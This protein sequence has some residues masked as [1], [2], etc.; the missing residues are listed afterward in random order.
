MK[1][2]IRFIDKQT[3]SDAVMRLFIQVNRVLSDDVVTALRTAEQR[4]SVPIAQCVLRRLGENLDAARELD[5][6]ICQDTGMAIVFAEVGEHVHIT[7]GTLF[8]AIND[9]VSRAYVEGKLRCSVVSDPLYDRKNTGDNTPA[10][11]HMTTVPGDT[12][13][14]IAAPKGFGSE[15]MSAL[16][17]LTPA[18]DEDTVADFVVSAVRA[19]GS[20]PCPP[21]L[22]G[23]GIGSDFEGVALLSKRALLRPVGTPHP[24]ARYAALEKKILNRVNALG[25]GPQGFGGDITALAVHIEYAPTHI[26]GLPCAVNINCHVIRHAEVIL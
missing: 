10:V 7:G 15:N 6:P 1:E 25:I 4:E 12:L 19:A 24:D 26:A 14:L 17:M 9:G 23:V 3:V 13:R 8:D 5:V 18:A 2:N 21:I 22:V 20:N 16:K 11:I